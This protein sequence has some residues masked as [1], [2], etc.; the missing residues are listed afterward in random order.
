MIAIRRLSVS[1]FAVA[2]LSV[3]TLGCSSKQVRRYQLE[4]KIVSVA[5]DR[6]EV[7][8]DHKAIPGFMEAMTMPYSLPDE[9]ALKSLQ[10]G[11]RIEATVAVARGKVWLENLRIVAPATAPSHTSVTKP[12]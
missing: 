6:H 4:G 10:P 11:D 2:F 1:L 9:Q 5:M 3:L 8:V 12:H 7:V